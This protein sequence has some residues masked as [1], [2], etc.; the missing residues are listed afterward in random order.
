MHTHGE[1]KNKSRGNE[2]DLPQLRTKETTK[3]EGETAFGKH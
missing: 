2:E 3:G 1:K